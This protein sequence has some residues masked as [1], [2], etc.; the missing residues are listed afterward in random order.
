M[1]IITAMI[2]PFML[3]KVTSVLEAKVCIEIVPVALMWTV[4]SRL[5]LD[6]TGGWRWRVTWVRRSS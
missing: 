6:A 2:Q 1:K 4:A 5:C 3:N